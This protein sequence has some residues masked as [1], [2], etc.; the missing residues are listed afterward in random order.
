MAKHRDDLTRGLP[1]PSTWVNSLMEFVGT[2]DANFRLERP[3]ATTVRVPAGAGNDQV[4]LG[5]AG[6]W[7]FIAANATATHPGGAAGTYDLYAAAAAND[8]TGV[9]PADSTNYGFTLT[10]RARVGGVPDPPPASGG[11]ALSRR[12]AEV[13]WDGA[14]I[15]RIINL[16]NRGRGGDPVVA[17]S[18][19]GEVPL[20]VQG[21]SGQTASLVYVED[22]AGASRLSVSPTGMVNAA[23]GYQ[24]NG[25]SI[26]QD[27][28]LT[29][30]PTAPTPAAADNDTSIATTAFVQSQK[31]S[32]ALTGTP[33]APTAA[34]DTNSTQIATTAYV[35]G[36]GYLKSATAG[37][38]YQPLDSDL[39]A[40][41]GI[42]TNGVLARTGAGAA[43]ARTITGTTNQV[44]VANGD[45]AAGN[46][47]ISLPQDVH[48]GASPSFLRLNLSGS[49]Y[50]AINLT[51][52]SLPTGILIGSDVQIGRNTSG[53]VA[54]LEVNNP[55]RAT[56]QQP[57][58]QAT[59]GVNMVAHQLTGA[60]GGNTTGTT[61]QAGGSGGSINVQAGA[62]GDAPAG[63]S[64]G[65]GGNITLYPGAGGSGAGA[66]AQRGQLLLGSDP[67]DRIAFYGAGGIP[68]R[69]GWG[70]T[71]AANFSGAV[72]RKTLTSSYTLNE[73]RDV[74]ATLV[75]ELRSYGLLGN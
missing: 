12:V 64:N 6:K 9:D 42:A 37:S 57:A 62:G 32:P 51:S 65:L 72:S 53:G 26:F 1:L 73:L 55:F 10:I 24:I 14:A 3:T 61:G 45:G 27:A 67:N 7:R 50:N 22:S 30:N 70:L 13:Y 44:S 33:T 52:T 58:A 28:A 21:A 35:V 38:T 75:D 11:T 20:R 15:T 39:T 66:A 4:A 46:P 60:K 29:G 69:N 8:L 34:V 17:G 59:N 18:S 36:Q 49:G 48:S 5:I 25:T 40:L 43:A 56:S 19:A 2:L 31:A 23:Q 54:F 68:R 41:A 16:V 71:L 47:T 74:V 63:G